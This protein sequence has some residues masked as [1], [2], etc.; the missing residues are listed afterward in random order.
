V[1]SRLTVFQGVHHTGSVK[2]I[3]TTLAM[4]PDDGFGIA[5]L[6]NGDSQDDANTEIL[7][8]VANT[9]FGI[10]SEVSHFNQTSVLARFIAMS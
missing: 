7:F 9:V 6:C 10:K 2:G 3:S 1:N 8:T 4:F 5:M